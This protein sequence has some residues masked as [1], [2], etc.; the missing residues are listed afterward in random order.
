MKNK[1][2][3]RDSRP[4]R[5]GVRSRQEWCLEARPTPEVSTLK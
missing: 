5:H 1:A 4:N 3:V 2:G